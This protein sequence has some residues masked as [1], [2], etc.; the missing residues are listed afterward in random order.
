MEMNNM[1][2]E[3]SL[4]KHRIAPLLLPALLLLPVFLPC[5][6]EDQPGNLEVQ[7]VKGLQNRTYYDLAEKHLK[8][9][10]ARTTEKTNKATYLFALADN[11]EKTAKAV[12][13]A[14]GV[15][16]DSRLQLREGHLAKAEKSYRDVLKIAPKHESA[17]KARFAIG[18]LLKQRATTLK[19]RWEKQIG[20]AHV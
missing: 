15:G 11:S 1:I 19:R 13:S 9:L 10:L 8:A 7:F 18:A 17:T 2:G 12:L 4:M 16:T 6:A 14:P 5:H 20:R 3:T